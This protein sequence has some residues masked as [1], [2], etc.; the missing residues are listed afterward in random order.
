MKATDHYDVTI[1]G[2]GARRG[3]LAHTVAGS[4]KSKAATSPLERLA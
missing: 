1:V 4:A 3:T 2:T